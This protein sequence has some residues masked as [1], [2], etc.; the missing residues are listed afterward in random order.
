MTAYD[1]LSQMIP[2]D[3]ALANK[4]L[5]VSLQQV[6]GIAKLS[7]PAFANAVSSMQTMYGLPL[8]N[9]QTAPIS[10]S[11]AN[12]WLSFG[13]GTGNYGT[14]NVSDIIGAAAGIPYTQNFNDIVAIMST[15]NLSYLNLIYTTMT[16][17]INGVYSDEF[18]GVVI[19]AGLP[20]AGTYASIDSAMYTGLIP[21][22][23]SEI[24]HLTVIYPTQT[25][26]LNNSWTAMVAHL[27]NEFSLQ[28]NS[29]INFGQ[30]VAHSK[31]AMYGF[32]FGLSGY[33]QDTSIGGTAQYIEAI[34][35]MSTLTGQAIVG[36][37][38]QG[39]INT[40]LTA[41][42]I[43]SSNNP[44]MTPNPRPAQATLT[45][46]QYPYPQSTTS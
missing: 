25:T 30:Y 20:A 40:A 38:R 42:G 10:Q 18:G 12:Y 5:A 23:N 4:A 43:N 46:A 45:P 22:A 27:E 2:P 1:K 33:G 39:Q 36:S 31:T 17:C 14:I 24:T 28:A 35:D 13:G 21:A 9:A 29:T 11:T 41:A 6:S 19:P 34:A 37:M 15:M 7:L 26:Q 8:V 32:I 16:N 44:I 3:Q